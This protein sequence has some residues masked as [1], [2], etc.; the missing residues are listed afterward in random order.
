MR[1]WCCGYDGQLVGI[2]LALQAP[3]RKGGK[4]EVNS[5]YIAVRLVGYNRDIHGCCGTTGKRYLTLHGGQRR[6]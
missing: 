2:V 4:I 5:N 3:Y 1:A 6:F